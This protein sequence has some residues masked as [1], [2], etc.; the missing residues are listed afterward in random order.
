MTCICG[1][2][3]DRHEHYRGGTDCGTCGPALCPH[4]Q[5]DDRLTCA[6][7]AIRID[8]RTPH[9]TITR[10][11]EQHGRRILGRPIINV[12]HA[13]LILVLCTTC[14]PRYGISLVTKE[15]A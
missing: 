7:C 5:P 1:H 13:R 3:E 10:H 14:D 6:G 2:P 4:Y 12:L 9:T 8:P 11:T 15:T